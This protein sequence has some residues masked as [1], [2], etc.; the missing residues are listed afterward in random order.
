MSLYCSESVLVSDR[1]IF[2]TV[3]NIMFWIWDENSAHNMDVLITT[4][5][6]PRTALSADM[7]MAPNCVVC[8]IHL[9]DG[10]P[11]RKP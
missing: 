8:L 3:A 6:K 4:Y 2:F 11:S 10:M 1:I 9:R 5:N 7:Q